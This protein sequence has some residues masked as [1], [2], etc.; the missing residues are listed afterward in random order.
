M[1]LSAPATLSLL[2]AAALV[3]TAHAQS[4]TSIGTLPGDG[5]SDCI[6]VSKNGNVLAGNSAGMNGNRAVRRTGSGALQDIG[7]LPNATDTWVF[8][9]SADG[10]AIV[11]LSQLP[12]REGAFRWTQGAPAD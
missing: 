1:K 6:A 8:G 5:Y 2:V 7:H 10:K 3:P 9:M 4:I 11:G 12:D